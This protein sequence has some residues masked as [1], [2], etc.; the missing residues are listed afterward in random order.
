[1]KRRDFF[2]KAGAAT[3]GVAAAATT[4]ATPAIAQGNITWRMVTTWPQN[5]PG[6]GVGAQRLADRITAASGGRL[7]I[8]VYAA[9]EMV[10]G[11]QALD[12]VIDGSA[13]MSHGAAYYWQNKSMGLS[14]YTGVPYGMTN[15]EL[16]AWVRHMGGQELWDEI[17]DQFGVQGF[18]SGDTGT[19]AGG[20]FR[21][22]L[23]GVSDIQGLR[24]RTPGLGGQVWEKLGASVTNLAAGDIFAALQ[25][26]TLDAAEFVGP[27]N[28]LA[29]GFYQIAKNYYFPSFIEP[30]L[31]TELV[32]DKAKYQELP[33]DLQELVKFVCQAEYDEVASDFAAND[34]RALQTLVNDHGVTV[35]QF[36]DEIMEAGAVAAKEILTDIRDNG[37]EL[38]KRVAESYVEAFNIVRQKTDG[39]DSL[40][41]RAREQYFTLD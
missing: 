16:A 9:G 28:D 6:L 31:A 35:R 2:R 20:W 27:Y 3:A 10:P 30:G 26:G 21:N 32:V 14:F 25:N 13:E 15:R 17:Y 38:T 5:F 7:S 41:L 37:D 12:A 23:T 8:Q 22:E 34:P 33:Q 19:Q 11:L 1:M 29:L 36:P 18:L 39:T 4:L 40:F 24:F